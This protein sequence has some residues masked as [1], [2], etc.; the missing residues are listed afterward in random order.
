LDRLGINV[1]NYNNRIA[2]MSETQRGNYTIS[3]LQ[4]AGLAE[5][6]D[7]YRKNN[8]S[9]IN[10]AN[11]EYDLNQSMAEL[12]EVLEPIKTEILG[13]INDLLSEHKEEIEKIIGVIG[14]FVTGVLKVVDAFL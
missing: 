4:K 10:A 12:A 7:Q 2:K 8:E 1:E 11:A 13:E 3:L 14:A 9:I 5:V 6:N